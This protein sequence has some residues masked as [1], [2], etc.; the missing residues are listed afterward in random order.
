[1]LQGLDKAGMVVNAYNPST[2]KT[3]DK[4]FK[5]SLS[6]IERLSLKQNKS[7]Q[8]CPK[9]NG[10]VKSQVTN[11]MEFLTQ[12]IKTASLRLHTSP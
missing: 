5:V 3:E 9:Y 2:Q 12:I 7:K 4:E 8:I 6:Y 11:I 10:P 1:M